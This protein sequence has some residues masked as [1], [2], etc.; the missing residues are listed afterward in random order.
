M[1]ELTGGAI[2]FKTKPTTILA[3]QKDQ[4]L[5]AFYTPRDVAQILT[6]WALIHPQD[7]V[8]DPSYGGCAFLK[9]AQTTLIKRGNN[10]PEKQIYGVDIDPD[11]QDYLS[12][13]I[14]AGARQ[15]Q[16]INNDFFNVDVN[17]FG[18]HLFSAIVG[19]PPYLRYHSIPK[20]LQKQAD[21]RL[22]ENGI[23]I[24]G[25]SSYW[26]YFL[27][28]SI[29]FL[30]RGGRLAMVLPGALLHTDYAAEVREH[31]TNRFERVS[32]YL[33]QE[34]IFDGTQEESVII[35][36]E[37][38]G[39]PNRN[40]HIGYVS[41]VIALAAA[42]EGGS[43]QIRVFNGEAGDGGWLRN[44]LDEETSQ[45]YDDLAAD[46]DVIRLGDWVETRIGV[47]T[48]NNSYF[49][50]S[51]QAREQRGISERYFLPIIK[52]PAFIAGLNATNRDLK[53]LK[54][55]NKDYLLLYPP[56]DLSRMPI[57]L[58]KYIEQGEEAGIPS[59]CKCKSRDPWYVVP[60][61]QAPAAFIP[62]MSASWPRLI[63]NK[64][65]Y[66]CTNNII[67]LSWKSRRPTSDWTRLALGTLSTLCQLS[68]EL[69]GR[70]YGGGVLKLEPTELTRLAIPLLPADVI[71]SLADQVD[72]LIR[73]NNLKE[74]TDV[75]D[76]ALMTVNPNLSAQRLELLRA[77]RNKLFLRRR[78]H[79]RDANKIAP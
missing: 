58:R 3:K 16:F 62:C 60:H 14:S 20:S 70:S 57:S 32:I 2:P 7:T 37:G 76:E 13:L 10:N 19:N 61:V 18:G 79:R 33:L 40:V 34:R 36:A 72:G 63:V 66:T 35:C 52:R 53:M 47:V 59:A 6:D 77:A 48:G 38:A 74:A 64:S 75:V 24:S 42:I 21:I 78:Q 8:L 54:K 9:S 4:T 25:R 68:A 73:Q 56:P 71:G 5:A 65:N 22:R 11:A 1:E 51:E 69:V 50:M 31:L 55:H 15:Q 23:T 27:L 39:Y 44:L 17:H 26:A 30:R 67:K 43:D 29:Q 45:L 41:S 46:A 49:I 12:D 28:Y